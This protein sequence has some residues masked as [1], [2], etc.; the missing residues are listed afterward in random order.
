MSTSPFYVTPVHRYQSR[1]TLDVHPRSY[2]KEF[3]EAV[4]IVQYQRS[5]V[6]PAKS[7]SDVVF[8]LHVLS[9]T[10]T[11]ILRIDRFLSC[12]SMILSA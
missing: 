8:C 10:L 1:S 5:T 3:A 9:K 7:D 12:E 2:S 11:F 4:P 6:L